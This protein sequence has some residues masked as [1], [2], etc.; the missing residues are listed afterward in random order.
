[1]L[2][3]LWS[4]AA[5][6]QTQ[7]AKSQD[8]RETETTH[9]EPNHGNPVLFDCNANRRALF[10]ARRATSF[11]DSTGILVQSENAIVRASRRGGKPLRQE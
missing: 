10:Q 4:F 6:R 8:N 3:L 7:Q 2:A 5:R 1:L 9:T 11:D